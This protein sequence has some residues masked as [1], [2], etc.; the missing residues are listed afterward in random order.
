MQ[1]MD[2]SMGQDT[3]TQYPHL[4]NLDEMPAMFAVPEVIAT[5]KV[6]GSSMRIGLFDG[7]IRLGGRRLEFTDLRRDT[8]EGLGFVSWVLTTGLDQRCREAFAGHNVLL[9]GEWHGSGTP[10]QGWP[11]VQKG[12]RYCA[13]N[14]FR[15]FDVKVDGRYLPFD[16]IA[17]WAA[18]VELKT[19]PVL[20]RGPPTQAAFDALIDTMSRVG[21]E[22]GIVDPENT[23]EGLVIRPPQLQWDDRGQVLMAK[24]K[25]GKWAERASRQ[26]HPRQPKQVKEIA[27]GA[28][29]FAEEFVTSMRLDHIL[30]QLRQEGLPVDHTATGEVLKRMGQDIKR[31]GAQ[32]LFDGNLAWKD[33]SPF[34]TQRSKALFVAWLKTEK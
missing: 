18:K 11:Q 29:A 13:G 8:K 9:Y 20:F 30:D 4:E 24:Y 27:P 26:R 23:L 5:E 3:F 33:V 19:M 15:V 25:V 7:A 21:A 28:P 10:A 16:E 17:T 31:E 34:V 32:A 14:N 12:I 1:L 2:A 6:H 22:H